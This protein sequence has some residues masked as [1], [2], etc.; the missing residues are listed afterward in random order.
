IVNDSDGARRATLLFSQGTTA[1]VGGAVMSNLHIRATEYT[2]GPNGPQAMPGVLP[3]ST[4]YTYAV[5]LSADE[6]PGQE[7]QFSKPVFTYI[8]NFLSFPVGGIVPVGYY[9]RLK[10]A[11]IPSDNGRVIKILSIDGGAAN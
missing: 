6:A 2:V 11:W 1:T 9:D 3:P 10:A 8:E 7:V 5:E 4:G